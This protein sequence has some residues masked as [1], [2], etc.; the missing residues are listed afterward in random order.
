M[1]LAHGSVFLGH[2]YLT[3]IHKHPS[4]R[5]CSRMAEDRLQNGTGSS[6]VFIPS[7]SLQTFPP[8]SCSYV[9]VSW[10]WWQ[11]SVPEPSIPVL[12]RITT[13]PSL[14][15]YVSCQSLISNSWLQLVT[16]CFIPR[17]TAFWFLAT[18]ILIK[19]HQIQPFLAMVKTAMITKYFF[20]YKEKQKKSLS[21]KPQQMHKHK[22]ITTRLENKCYK[23]H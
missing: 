19:F 5:S 12:L 17:S 20:Y 3:C 21:L 9:L 8:L 15:I 2:I 23:N 22:N 1:H 6:F 16:S 13:S 14:L 11:N 18:T 10:I 4:L 7:T